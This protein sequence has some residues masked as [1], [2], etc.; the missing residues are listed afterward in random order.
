MQTQ[1][2]A[3]I[4]RKLKERATQEQ[5]SGAV[6]IR[7]GRADLFC[8]AYGL[9]NRTW[10]VKNAPQTRFRIASVGKM[11]TAVAVLQLI[12]AGR[13]SFDTRT[14]EYLDLAESRISGEVS[15]R[16][17]LT[18]TSGIADWI[19]ENAPDFDAVWAQFC[20]DHPLYLLRGD[21][22]YLPLFSTLEPYDPV[23]KKYCYSNAGFILLGLMIEKA[24][25]RTYF[26]YVRANVFRRAGML[27]T[28]FLDLDDVAPGVAEGYVP[29]RNADG[30][31][32]GWRKNIYS[33]T[34]GSAADGG[35]T[36]TV[37]DLARFTRALRTGRLLPR[38]LAESML[39]PRADAS[40]EGPGWMYGYGCFI[41]MGEKGN[42]VRWGHTGEEDGVSCRLD[43]YPEQK[44]DVVIL[45]NQSSCAGRISRDIHE[46]IMGER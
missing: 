1:F 46:A 2:S 7:K 43:Y 36:S 12:D 14:V 25:G 21:A 34:A 24:S 5:F 19:N 20:K 28:D 41:L 29:I 27:D 33:T 44:L 26:D 37:A 32:I 31:R 15:I 45:G 10:N 18:M 6:L 30:A 35:A 42:V 13:L 23:G 22:D 40:A 38:E 9:A 17:L 8:R 16:H 4:A 39:T 11:F 3:V